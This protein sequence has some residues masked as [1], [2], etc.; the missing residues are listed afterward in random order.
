MAD[1]EAKKTT[2][3]NKGAKDKPPQ[4]IQ[5]YWDQAG[6]PD[7]VDEIDQLSGRLE[8][9]AACADNI[10]Q[11]VLEK[12]RELK[13]QIQELETDVKRR[14]KE[15][16]NQSKRLESVK[17]EWLSSLNNLVGNIN[18][19]FSKFFGIM[20]FA[21][22]VQLHTGSHEN[23]F[24]NYGIKILVKYRDTEPLQ[25][26][27]PHHQSG[28]ERSVATAIYMLALQALTT[29]PFRC[30]D[31]INQGMDARNERLVFE[32]LVETSCQETNSQYFL[33]TPKLLTGLAYNP[34]MNV[35]IVH[36]GHEML[37]HSE[38]NIDSI[39][40]NLKSI[41]SA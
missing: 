16:Q 4:E 5:D 37:H 27:T 6:F 40:E 31:E 1:G 14:G 39:Y 24:D 7:S 20:G 19:R 29:V 36:N 2:G 9:Q 32:L 38:W 23:D 25:E 15:K 18:T 8:A 30:V 22:G 26:L 3:L 10:N 13:E 12:Y 17:E 34:R 21:G 28:G 11:S 35:L 41:E 33:L